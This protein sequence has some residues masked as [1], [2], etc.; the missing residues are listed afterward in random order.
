VD[1]K[2]M[3]LGKEKGNGDYVC[4]VSFNDVRILIL[5]RKG[6]MED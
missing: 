4:V 5:C 2:N 6:T 3:V 1:F